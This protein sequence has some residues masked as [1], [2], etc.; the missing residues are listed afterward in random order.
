M[1]CL[2][3][4]LLAGRGYF[5]RIHQSVDLADFHSRSGRLQRHGPSLS[6]VFEG[7]QTLGGSG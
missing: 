3:H 6:E 7:D 5:C 4:C 2:V 1:V